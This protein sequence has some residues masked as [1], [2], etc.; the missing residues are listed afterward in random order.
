M[1]KILGLC[2]L[3]FTIYRTVRALLANA[4]R[5]YEVLSELTRLMHYI[6]TEIKAYMKPI[7]AILSSFSSPVLKKYEICEHIKRRDTDAI[8]TTDI[9]PKRARELL[10]ELALGYGGA[11][12]ERE[13]SR[14]ESLAEEFE[15]L[16]HLSRDSLSTKSR[17]YTTL[18]ASL[19]FAVIIFVI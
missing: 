5:E 4:G 13:L 2:I 19:C 10:S 18:G 6:H 7:D 11:E 1:L 17:L 3:I 8:M 14:V 9:L 15:R 16:A 12:C